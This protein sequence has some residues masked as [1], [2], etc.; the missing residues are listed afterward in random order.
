[1]KYIEKGI[2]ILN[3]ILKLLE[4]IKKEN[5]GNLKPEEEDVRDVP[6]S[7]VTKAVVKDKEYLNTTINELETYNQGKLGICVGTA[8]TTQMELLYPDKNFSVRFSYR[9]AK[10]L[11]KLKY[12]KDFEG[13]WGRT[14]AKA[15]KDFGIAT[16]NTRPESFNLVHWL[17]INFTFGKKEMKEAKKYKIKGYV[18]AY[19]ENEIKTS[20]KKYGSVTTTINAKSMWNRTSGYHRIVLVGWNKDGFLFRNSWGKSDLL[21]LPYSAQRWNTIAYIKSETDKK[22]ID[23]HIKKVEGKYKYFN[24]K[25]SY[26]INPDFMKIIDKIRGELGR[27]MIIRSGFRTKAH[28]KAIGGVINSRHLSGNAIDVKR[29]DGKFAYDLIGLAYKYNIYGIE[30]ATGHIHLDYRPKKDR[31][32]FYGR[33]R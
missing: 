2:D 19:S 15:H 16:V 32:T 26:K 12:K 21:T 20:I 3:Y 18:F 13:T 24:S 22:K 14:M 6:V 30:I 8:H 4:F 33:S 10:Y 25:E 27:P 11:D 7:A 23:K 28:N 9:I 29:L 5:L 1:M 31:A 17:Y